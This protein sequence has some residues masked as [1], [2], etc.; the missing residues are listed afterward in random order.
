MKKMVVANWKMSLSVAQ[1][2]KLAAR[3]AR[4]K[5][6]ALL[7]LVVCPSFLAQAGVSTILKRSKLF[8]GAQNCSQKEWGAYT[9]EVSPRDLLSLGCQYVLLGHSERRHLFHETDEEICDKVAFLIAHFPTLIPIVC[10]GETRDERARGITLRVLSRQLRIMRLRAL[11]R[12]ACRRIILAY[13]PVWA[14]G[15][16][17]VCSIAD[18]EAAKAHIKKEAPF[19]SRILYGGSVNEQTILSFCRAS[20]D[21][22][23][24]VG[25]ASTSYE[26]LRALCMKI[27]H[28]VQ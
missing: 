5:F 28:A 10:I 25:S 7:D 21:G 26:S 9:G 20:D 12:T 6:G 15:T 1:S 24:I 18:W 19:V 22:G 16:G 4:T 2:Q 17:D 3:L 11:S 13:E 23:V 14:V 8:L 27:T